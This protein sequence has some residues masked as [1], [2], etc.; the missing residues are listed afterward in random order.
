MVKHFPADLHLHS[1]ASGHAFNTI[2]EITRFAQKNEYGLIGI[3]DHG[4]KMEGAPHS[5]YF[6]MLNRLPH[7]AGN[8]Q[9]LYGCEANILDEYGNVDLPN[10][11]IRTLDYVIAGL[12]RRTPYQGHTIAE[13]TRA[14]VSAIASGRI[15]IISHP[16]SLGFLA[17]AKEI[18]HFAAQHYVILEVNK[19][20]VLEAIRKNREDVIA[21][22]AALFFEAQVMGVPLLFG[23]DAH[24]ISEMGLTQDEVSLI[25][26][27]YQLDLCSVVNTRPD[28]LQQFL[29]KH[30]MIREGITNGA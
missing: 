7:M 28:L 21:S 14:I 29:Q 1:I 19:T 12:H 4:P 9:V 25:D 23:S 11:L 10:S 16:V 26:R 18:V 22:S 13:H 20:V 17:D 5:G 2:D 27:V 8:T 30:R 24:H 3:S 6:E 15:D